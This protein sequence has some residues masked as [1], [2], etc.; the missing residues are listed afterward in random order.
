MYD[1]MNFDIFEIL[2]VLSKLIP[3]VTSS[4]PLTK[5]DRKGFR[6]NISFY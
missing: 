3:D 4:I 6:L 2:R 5:N 1:K